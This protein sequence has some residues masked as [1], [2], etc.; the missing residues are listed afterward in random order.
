MS[1]A[2]LPLLILL[3]AAPAAAVEPAGQRRE[4]A[5]RVYGETIVQ[6]RIVVRIPRLPASRMALGAPASTQIR[7]DEKKADRCVRVQDLAAA[8]ITANDSVDLLVNGGGR[9]RARFHDDC[10]TLDFYS[11]FYVRMPADG[12]MCADRDTIRSRSGG[13]CRIDSFRRLVPRK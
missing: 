13:E 10:R 11:G 6:R 2:R 8:S 4:P 5:Q 7:W 3:A 12:K 9:L 1:V